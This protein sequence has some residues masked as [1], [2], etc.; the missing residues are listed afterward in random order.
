MM[1][2]SAEGD[3]PVVT[4]AV[5]PSET[6]GRYLETI[7]YIEHED[8]VARPGRLAEWLG[9]SAPTVTVSLQRLARDGWVSLLSDRSI[10][11]TDTGQRAAAEVVR[12][13]RILERWL[14][15]ILE[16]DWVAADREAALLAHGVSDLVLERLDALLGKPSTCPHG[17]AIPGRSPPPG[18]RPI[19]LAE[20]SPSTVTRVLRIS[21]VAEHEA[22][23]LLATL[24][25]DG[26]VP[27]ARVNVASHGADLHQVEVGGRMVE[28]GD[29]IARS[30]WV[31]TPGPSA[32]LTGSGLLG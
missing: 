19:R 7:Y 23:Q 32:E 8:E 10:R 22:P 25:S 15:D 31:E 5:A 26:L 11:L 12:R 9:V 21:E 24:H 18:G 16:L 14:T 17:N 20:L 6:A 1:A 30:V 3:E 27:G 28:V 29:A 4:T 2:I 13:H